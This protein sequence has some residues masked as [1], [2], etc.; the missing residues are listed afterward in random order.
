MLAK[1]TVYGLAVLTI[2]ITSSFIATAGT[3]DFESYADGANLNG[4][5]LGDVTLST[6]GG[7]VEV[8]D[9]RF[10]VGYHSATKAIFNGNPF[11]Q[12]NPLVGVFDTPVVSVSLWAGD[13]H[14]DTNDSWTLSVYDAAVGGTLLG[15]VTENGAG[16]NGN[17]YR[18]LSLSFPGIVRFEA[19]SDTGVGFDDLSYVIPEPGTLALALAGLLAC[20]TLRKRA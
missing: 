10:T 6:P 8:F 16:W 15:T 19:T 13:D 11:P 12:T 14:S 4:V 2:F 5:D 3:I 17:Q 7:N 20:T 18:Q 9:D 1:K